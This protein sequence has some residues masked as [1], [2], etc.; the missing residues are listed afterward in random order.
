MKLTIGKEKS[1]P[2]RGVKDLPFHH[3]YLIYVKK[4]ID[5]I[6][7]DEILRDDYIL[8]YANGLAVVFYNESNTRNIINTINEWSRNNGL[9]VNKRNSGIFQAL[10][11]RQH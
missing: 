6:K 7:N 9:I 4:L 3:T 11:K 5:E 2:Q 1:P 8:I 10:G